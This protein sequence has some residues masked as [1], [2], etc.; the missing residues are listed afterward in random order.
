M[1]HAPRISPARIR[2]KRLLERLR[3]KIVLLVEDDDEFRRLLSSVLTAE[4]YAVIEAAN[5]DDA[6]DWLGPWAMEG[7]LEFAPDLIVSDIRM[8]YFTG[9]EILEGVQVASEYVPVILMTAFPDAE[10]LLHAGRLGAVCVLAK[11]FEMSQ[12]RNAV[13]SA[14]DPIELEPPNAPRGGCR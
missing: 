12:F 10:T 6:F 2:K 14:L 13:R 5:G 1:E 8:P 4:G 7:A 3:Q 9:L 11:P